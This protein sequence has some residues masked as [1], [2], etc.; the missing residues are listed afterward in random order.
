MSE[1]ED[2]WRL[3][4]NEMTCYYVC[5]RVGVRHSSRRQQ[6]VAVGARRLAGRQQQQSPLCLTAAQQTQS[7]RSSRRLAVMILPTCQFIQANF[8]EPDVRSSVLQ[9][10]RRRGLSAYIKKKA[11]DPLDTYVPPVLQARQQLLKAGGIMGA[12]LTSAA[13]CH[14]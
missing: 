14:S 5:R 12:R 8:V 13:C 10:G 3:K 11:L 2:V 7:R 9:G 1:F 4:R 6:K